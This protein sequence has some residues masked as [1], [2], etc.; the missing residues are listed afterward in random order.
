MNVNLKSKNLDAKYFGSWD[1]YD[2]F[3]QSWCVEYLSDEEKAKGIATD[4]EIL[5]ASYGGAS[6]EGDAYVLFRRDGKLYEVHG[7][8][9]SCYG[10]EGQ[11]EPEEVTP[12]VLAM[13]LDPMGLDERGQDNT[14][15]LVDHEPDVLVAYSFICL[16]LNLNRLLG[17]PEVPNAEED[18]Q[19]A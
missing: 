8:H 5:I 10:L 9:C 6:Y 16:A 11:W 15:F 19:G 13:R 18:A 4:D 2:E 17:S 7:S 14:Y 3:Y 1:N 12:V